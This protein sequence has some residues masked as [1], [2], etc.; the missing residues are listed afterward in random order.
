MKEFMR[1][2]TMLA[3]QWHVHEH[4]GTVS[5]QLHVHC[6]NAQL[7]LAC[8]VLAFAGCLHFALRHVRVFGL[9][10]SYLSLC[11]S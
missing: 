4:R 5:V 11:L 10:P 8:P 9:V 6:R 3:L 2:N 1:S 7:T